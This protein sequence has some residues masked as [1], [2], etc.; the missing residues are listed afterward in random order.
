MLTRLRH[1]LGQWAIDWNLREPVDPTDYDPTDP[2][3]LR[4]P[5]FERVSYF[6]FE[7]YP[8]K[9]VTMIPAPPD[10]SEHW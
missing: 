1:F 8:L 9:R 3:D 5:P 7:G 6:D 2:T 10:D 4:V